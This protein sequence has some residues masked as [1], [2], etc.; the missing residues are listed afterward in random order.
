MKK[1][2]G[3]TMLI[4]FPPRCVSPDVFDWEL[5]Q[6]T[7]YHASSSLLV[8]AVISILECE[9]PFNRPQL[10]MQ[11]A[12]GFVTSEMAFH[13]GASHL[14]EHRYLDLGPDPHGRP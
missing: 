9:Q 4:I 7:V 3:I 11:I 13:G 2:K 12:S 14:E 8:V 6:Y 1:A 5:V 10:L